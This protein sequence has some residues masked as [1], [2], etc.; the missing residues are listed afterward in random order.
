[1]V[2]AR[3][4]NRG[5]DL[6]TMAA[7]GVVLLGLGAIAQAQTAAPAPAANPHAGHTMPASAPTAGD[8]ASVKE[9]KAVND[10]MHKDM[11]IAFTGKTDVDFVRGMIPHHQG[12]IE[13]AEVQ[14]KYGKDA[15]IRKLAKDIIKAQKSE[16]A[17]MK[18]WLV[19]NDKK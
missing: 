15:K 1:M 8:A 11:G 12:A 2:M 14:L 16:I 4:M 3:W 17:M 18:A 7:A 9:F 5:R 10:K 13:M 6:A 19:K